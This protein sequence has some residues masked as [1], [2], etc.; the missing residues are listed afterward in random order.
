MTN[1]YNPHMSK[2]QPKQAEPRPLFQI[3]GDAF[4]SKNNKKSP[5]SSQLVFL[6]AIIALLSLVLIIP[7][8]K[9]S[10]STNMGGNVFAYGIGVI[11]ILAGLLQNKNDK[12]ALGILLLTS[13]ISVVALIIFT[14]F[15]GFFIC[16]QF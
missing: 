5:S 7:R 14:T 3:I 8:M 15:F 6:G 1:P 2:K 13:L 4:N 9:H 12:Q 16:W 10:C 11:V